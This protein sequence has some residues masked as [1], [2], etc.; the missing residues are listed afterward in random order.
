MTKQDV[1]F[2]GADPAWASPPVP[3]WVDY[4][5]AMYGTGDLDGLALTR[6]REQSRHTMIMDLG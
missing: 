4:D 6:T 5:R 1:T 2:F 3:G